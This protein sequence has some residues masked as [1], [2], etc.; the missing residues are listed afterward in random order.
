[1]IVNEDFKDESCEKEPDYF[2]VNIFINKNWEGLVLD[3]SSLLKKT[4]ITSEL[5]YTF[6]MKIDSNLI[7]KA[8]NIVLI[9]DSW[10]TDLYYSIRVISSLS[11]NL[12]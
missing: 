10:K 4:P 3:L 5:T 8:L 7:D 6:K 1:M 2:G 12:T 9:Q 11:F